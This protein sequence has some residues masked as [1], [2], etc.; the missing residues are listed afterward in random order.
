MAEI[1]NTTGRYSLDFV[2]LPSEY[3]EK[4]NEFMGQY[5]ELSDK[6]IFNKISDTKAQVSSNVLNQHINNLDALYQMSGMVTDST[7]SR[8]QLVKQVLTADSGT[9]NSYSLVETQFFGGT[10]LLL[11]FL[12]L[13]AIWRR[14]FFGGFGGGF[15]R[16]PFY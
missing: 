16:G 13:A 7:K 8:I 6:E 1:I 9:S 3:I 2:M 11:W 4:F 14:P 5:G 10:S 15:F 12:I